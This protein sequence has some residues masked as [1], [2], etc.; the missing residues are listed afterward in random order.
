MGTS[1]RD[2]SLEASLDDPPV[3]PGACSSIAS[4]RR[5]TFEMD[6]EKDATL[7]SAPRYRWKYGRTF[8]PMLRHISLL[9]SNSTFRNTTSGFGRG[10]LAQF[11]IQGA[12]RA[13]PSRVKIDDDEAFAGVG[14][15]GEELVR[16]V[17]VSHV[18]GGIFLPPR[19]LGIHAAAHCL[20]GRRDGKGGVSKKAR[21]EASAGRGKEVRTGGFRDVNICSPLAGGEAGGRD[22]SG[23]AP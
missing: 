17:H 23:D 21:D 9:S 4:R 12:A 19:V 13:A 15:R 1:S 5:P 22:G 8:T 14:E 18:I 20:E 7:P 11:G 16:A 6:A 10:D 2:S 3:D